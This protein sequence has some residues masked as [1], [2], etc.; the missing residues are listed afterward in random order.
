MFSGSWKESEEHRVSLDIP[1]PNITTEGLYKPTIIHT[2][3]DLSQKVH[4]IATILHHR[5]HFVLGSTYKKWVWYISSTWM[6]S[7]FW[8]YYSGWKKIFERYFEAHIQTRVQLERIPESH[9]LGDG[10]KLAQ[11]D[12]FAVKLLVVARDTLIII[13]LFPQPWTWPSAPCIETRSTCRP[14]TSL[15]PWPLQPCYRWLACTHTMLAW[16][17]SSSHTSH[18]YI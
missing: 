15:V 16:N 2:H 8:L 14:P 7:I 5:E 6:Q 3:R 11:K 4:L 9:H 18:R 13:F 17:Y 1:D 10:G 12:T